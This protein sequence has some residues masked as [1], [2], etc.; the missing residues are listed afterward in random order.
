MR[1]LVFSDGNQ[2]LCKLHASSLHNCDVQMSPVNAHTRAMSS[3]HYAKQHP[4]LF[5]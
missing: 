5:A 2:I 3:M 1:Q 4:I